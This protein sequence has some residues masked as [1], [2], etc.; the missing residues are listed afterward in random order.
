MNILQQEEQ[1][2]EIVPTVEPSTLGNHDET[3]MFEVYIERDDEEPAD[4]L[5]EPE[6]VASEPI[7]AALENLRRF[8]YT[9]R[10]REPLTEP[11]PPNNL[12]VPLDQVSSNTFLMMSLRH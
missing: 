11:N 4:E 1:N 12:E 9:F 10:R 5:P 3:L 6:H 7:Y 8:G 2:F